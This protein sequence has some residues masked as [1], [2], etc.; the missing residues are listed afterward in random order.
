MS[1]FTDNWQGLAGG[2]IFATIVK[3]I[4]DRKLNKADFL[5]KVENIYSGLVDELKT[6]RDLLREENRSFKEDIR[7]LQD[8]FNT[9]QLA[10][11]KEVE[12]SQNWEKLHRE[13]SDKYNLLE[14]E[15]LALNDK[16]DALSNDHEELKVFCEKLKTELDK[17]K[18]NSK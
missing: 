12:Q 18:K 9:I 17:H 3:Y 8:Q 4:S 10:Y 15:N 1:W 7:K 6:D 13:L 11:A 2:G 16:Y 14:K 5:S